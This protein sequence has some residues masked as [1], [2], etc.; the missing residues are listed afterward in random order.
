MPRMPYER[1]PRVLSSRAISLTSE[2]VL[3]V[4]WSKEDALQA[5][6]WARDAEIGILGGHVWVDHK[7]RW[8]AG[9]DGWSCE[10]GESG[11]AWSAFVARSCQQAETFV[12]W[13]PER[14]PQRHIYSIEFADIAS[15]LE[16]QLSG[17][18]EVIKRELAS[19]DARFFPLG[20]R[21][22]EPEVRESM[23]G[24]VDIEIVLRREGGP[25]AR[26]FYRILDAGAAI[27]SEREVRDALRQDIED[28]LIQIGQ[29][30][31]RPTTGRHPPPET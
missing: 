10:A 22:S 12:S 3:D 9:V 21:W 19:F 4:A 17:M 2:G 6:Q 7:G 25:L 24:R 16:L 31:T 28:L 13:Y 14:V 15:F 5:V 8:T 23:L 20:I 18:R 26:L 29:A 30:A 1:I 11:E 27:L